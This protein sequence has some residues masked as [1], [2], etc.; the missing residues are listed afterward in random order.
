MGNNEQSTVAKI[1][2]QTLTSPKDNSVILYDAAQKTWVR[3]EEPVAVFSAQHP[4]EVLPALRQIDRAVQEE[5][6]H[7]AGFLGYESAPAFD[8]A[9]VTHRSGSLPLLW[10]GLYQRP[11]PI[12]I[13]VH[14]NSSD[15]SQIEW[16]SAVSRSA[17]RQS[18]DQIKDQIALGN[19]YQVNFTLRLRSL[20]REDPWQFFLMLQQAQR[21]DYAAYVDIGRFVICSASPELF[22][23]LEGDKIETRPMKGTAR[24]GLTYAQDQH[25]ADWLLNSEKDRAENVMIV[26]MVRNDLGRIA[27]VGSVRADKLFQ[28][29]R[30][31]TVWQMTSTV[32]A[33]TS[34]AL[35]EILTALFPCASITGAPKFS[36]MKIIFDLES[37]A[38][39]I[40]TG[41]IGFLAPERRAQFN[42]AIRTVWIDRQTGQAE[43]GVGGGIVWDST[44]EGEYEECQTKASLLTHHRPEF[45]LLETL[46]WQP[47][48]GYFLEALHFKR[49]HDSAQYFDIPFD[50]PAVQE[51][52]HA[53]AAGLAPEPYLVRLLLDENGCLNS[54]AKPLKD[55]PAPSPVRL[56]LAEHPV[57]S[58]DLFLYHK[59][60]HRRVYEAHSF[61]PTQ[62][63]DVL[64]WNEHGELTETRIANILIQLGGEWLTPPISCGL[65]A[66][67]Y[68]AWM[69]A[70]GMAKERILTLDDLVQ[71][72]NLAVINAVRKQR[73][74]MLIGE[75]VASSPIR[76]TG[77]SPTWT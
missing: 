38:R 67:T 25:Q 42:V 15:F 49:L 23:R 7:A 72:E 75:V 28:I 50:R 4:E 63:D 17:Y 59:T 10:F 66:G 58:Q 77:A 29:E 3:F 55:A 57:N 56:K 21:A 44:T 61:D 69:L 41:C 37:E 74:A 51:H 27:K 16:T 19:T 20:F 32:T 34:A 36:T 2:D 5:C 47:A 53:L 43:Y 12:A 22:F 8:P 14:S 39:Q 46:L 11:D 70:N 60:T 62:V 9:M 13:P 71:C 40:Y 52:L 45:K 1:L 64:L 31:P 54:E 33:Q 30:Y 18:I 76:E 24:R 48:E 68:R 6:L 35:P 65:L 73:P 26:D